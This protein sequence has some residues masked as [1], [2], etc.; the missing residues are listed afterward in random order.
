M[1][2][3]LVGAIGAGLFIYGKKQG[4][5]P[6]MLAGITLSIYPYFVPNAWVMLGIA[7]VIVAGVWIAVRRGY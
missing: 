7:V 4:R 5:L 1:L 3:L 2:S 6:Q